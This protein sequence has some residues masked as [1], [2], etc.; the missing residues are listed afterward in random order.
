MADM[1]RASKQVILELKKNIGQFNELITD[2]I[3]EMLSDARKLY[4]CWQDDQ[5][6]EFLNYTE[7]IANELKSHITILE[8]VEYNLK[9]IADKF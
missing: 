8:S 7:Q 3:R 9:V 4:D 5:Y 2:E 1:G 6:K